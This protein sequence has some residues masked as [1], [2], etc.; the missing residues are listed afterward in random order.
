LR[1]LRLPEE[2]IEPSP[3]PLNGA[4]AALD[5]G[6]ARDGWLVFNPVE[7]VWGVPVPLEGRAF[8]VGRWWDCV[9]ALNPRTIWL[10][11][12]VGPDANAGLDHD[13][14]TLVVEYDGVL[15]QEV[16]RLE[17]SQS[18]RL[19]AA[20]PDGLILRPSLVTGDRDND[21]LLLRPWHSDEARLLTSGWDVVAC[22][23]SLLAV[24][25]RDGD[26][27]LVDTATR[28]EVPVGK[29]LPGEWRFSGSF[30]PD[31]AWLAMSVHE[32]STETWYADR[33]PDEAY[34]PQG[35]DLGPWF[36][37]RLQ[38]PAYLATAKETGKRLSEP[39]WTRLALI[40]CA[41][42]AVT[43][44]EDRFDGGASTPLWSQDGS[45]LIFN[46]ATRMFACHV[47]ESPLRLTRIVRRRGR[48]GPLV[49]VTAI[50]R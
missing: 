1:L 17:L 39:R 44:T 38:D 2:T 25:H 27:T 18:L 46:T 3:V 8:R 31:G 41:T 22:H 15:R 4:S 7:E 23:D 12:P 42:G 24:E 5:R 26:L 32:E 10:A 33:L 43:M 34:P 35:E 36:A 28:T 11:N 40:D 20:V 21:V 47:R 14:P 19:E 49:D 37:S 9:P 48:P 6:F 29:P 45:W 30:A 50:T 16:R 13:A